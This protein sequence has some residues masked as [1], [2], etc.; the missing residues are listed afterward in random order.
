M[1]PEHAIVASNHTY[2]PLVLS[3]EHIMADIYGLTGG[4]GCGK[5]SIAKQLA[6]IPGFRIFDTDSVAKKMLESDVHRDAVN[7]IVG[8]D[9]YLH[10]TLEKARLAEILFSDAE[11]RRAIEALV[12]PGIWA[13]IHLI[14]RDMPPQ[15][16]LIV[17]SALIYEQHTENLFKGI[18]AAYCPNNIADRRLRK[19]RGML[20]GDI[21]ARRAAQLPAEEKAKRADYVINTSGRRREVAVRTVSLAQ[22]LLSALNP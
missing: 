15:S 12:G 14:A 6:T 10:G 20:S 16:I 17:E 22:K 8:E 21:A 19:G 1:S 18:I 4:I 2:L 7:A 9:V 3:E 5:S 13:R 11:K